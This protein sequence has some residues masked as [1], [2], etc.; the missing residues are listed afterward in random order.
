[1]TWLLMIAFGAYHG[2]N[3]GMGWLFALSNGLQ[4]RS[5][6]G[7]WVS[8]LPIAAGHA[9]SVLIAALAVL[10]GLRFFSSR[11]VQFVMATLLLGFGAYK[12]K[13]YYRHPRWVGMKVGS[14]GLFAWSFIMATAHGAGLMIAP[15]LAG[16]AAETT[17]PAHHAG[18][19]HLSHG[20]GWTGPQI[21]LAV[22]LHTLSML[23]VMGLVALVVYRYVGLSI[24]R[25]GWINF[26]LIWAVALLGAAGI[27]LVSAVL[28]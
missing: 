6:R 10:I 17:V 15:I 18:H 23:V 8:L 19:E 1:M 14:A 5:V 27:A 4:R 16:A 9:A 3:P 28:G 12:L 7:I 13:N 21:A 24:L 2:L 20:Q 26:D 22:A 25:R 11:A